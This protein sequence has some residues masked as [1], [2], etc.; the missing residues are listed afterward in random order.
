MALLATNITLDLD[1][2][3]SR[4]EGRRMLSR[5]RNNQ[6][7]VLR[8]LVPG[9]TKS[10]CCVCCNA[11]SFCPMCSM[12]LCCDDAK[13]VAS[14]RD[15]SKYI[16]IRENSIEWNDPEVVWMTGSCLGIDPCLYDVQ[17]RPHVIYY[18]DPDLSAHDRS[19]A[20]LQRVPNVL[21]RRKRRTH[22]VKLTVLLSHVLP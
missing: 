4:I 11:P 13:Y 14:K 16:F 3:T 7:R 9:E 6:I 12:C 22:P 21:V 2:S 1:G 15:A 10:G 19:H 8:S 18:D 17:D 5:K 20:L